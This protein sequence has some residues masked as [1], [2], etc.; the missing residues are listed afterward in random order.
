[1]HGEG[2]HAI[3]QSRRRGAVVEDVA[4]VAVAE[5]A[6][7]GGADHHEGAV[8]GFD[9]VFFGDGLVEAGPAGAGV[10]FGG[11]EEEGEVAGAAAEEAGAVFIPTVAGE[12]ALG[13]FVAEDPI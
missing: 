5:A 11:A 8:D 7:D 4:E 9:D 2:V 10:E 1:M 12:G 6:G 3:P 13:G